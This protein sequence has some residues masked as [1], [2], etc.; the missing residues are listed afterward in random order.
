MHVEFMHAALCEPVK[1]GIMHVSMI[2]RHAHL[3]S[4]IF[5]LRYLPLV[6]LYSKLSK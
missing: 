5:T 6:D 2:S 1:G 3:S 4:I